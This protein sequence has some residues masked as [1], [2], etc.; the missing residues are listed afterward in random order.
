MVPVVFFALF[1]VFALFCAGR[2]VRVLIV[3]VIIIMTLGYALHVAGVFNTSADAG[4]FHHRPSQGSI[5][6]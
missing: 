4:K 5:D 6:Q 3:P 2:V 1:T